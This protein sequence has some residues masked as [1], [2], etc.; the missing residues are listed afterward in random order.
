MLTKLAIS[1]E[2]VN[3]IRIACTLQLDYVQRPSWQAQIKGKKTWQV[4]P[5]PECDDVCS[6]FNTTV[7][8]GE[9]SESNY[10]STICIQLLFTSFLI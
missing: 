7:H 2:R 10:N 4:I 5:V 9:I 3:I 6:S 1:S 8:P